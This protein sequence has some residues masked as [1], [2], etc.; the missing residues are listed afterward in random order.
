MIPL[1]LATVLPAARTSLFVDKS[2]VVIV[3]GRVPGLCWLGRWSACLPSAQFRGF[4]SHRGVHTR[5]FFQDF[6]SCS[7]IDC[8]AESARA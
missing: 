7:R 2:W 5:N 6:F 4:E 8:V 1:V 3:S